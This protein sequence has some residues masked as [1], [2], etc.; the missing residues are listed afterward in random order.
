MSHRK[1]ETSPSSCE[2]STSN[3]PLEAERLGSQQGIPGSLSSGPGKKLSRTAVYAR[4]STELQRETSI[5]DQVD[6]CKRA[7]V[8]LG[9][10]VEDLRVFKDEAI[11]GKKSATAKRAGYQDLLRAIKG[12]ELDV[13]VCDQQCRLARSANEALAFFDEL[14][15]YKVR[16]VTADGFDSNNMTAELLFGIKSVFNAFYVDETR[17]RVQRSMAG[18]FERGVMVTAVPYGYS[19]DRSQDGVT[20]WVINEKQAEVMREVYTRR[21]QGM[22]LTQIAAVL[23]ANGVPTPQPERGIDGADK[24]WRHSGLWPMIRNTIYF[25]LYTVRLTTGKDAPGTVTRLIPEL[26]IVSHEDWLQAQTKESSRKAGN[27][28]GRVFG[29]VKHVFT[30]LL[31]CG[32]CGTRLSVHRLVNSTA[33]SLNCVQCENATRV[34]VCHRPVW[35][36][37][38]KGVRY[39]LQTLLNRMMQGD[40]LKQFH[41]KLRERL[42]GGRGA[43]L[44]EAKAQLDK[45]QRV[46]ARLIQMLDN[47][48]MSDE[49]LSRK[50]QSSCEQCLL[51]QR[52]V[53]DL[54][55]AVKQTDID[56]IHA[57][58]AVNVEGVID[59]FLTPQAEA[60]K[61]NAIL[62]S[63]FSQITLLY[64]PDRY[65]AIFEVHVVP[66]AVVAT[67]TGTPVLVNDHQVLHLCLITSGSRYPSWTLHD[68]T[69]DELADVLE[70]T[71]QAKSGD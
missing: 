49:D 37:S 24:Y 1:T 10:S 51:L 26:A 70:L 5:D 16:L 15:A 20:K 71:G 6:A 69:P 47:L 42:A 22:S 3:L 45:A 55:V 23:N 66:G 30:G 61:A 35:H 44:L 2:R 8:R 29:G 32:T 25:G 40:V 7:L 18:N 36:L 59:Q 43:E 58:L 60:H 53:A 52:R 56:A 48:S 54:E 34:G 68:L 62:K 12:G 13:I 67:A 9:H 57:Q 21:C 28:V 50:Y 64:K 41:D 63:V 11:S 27:G 4:Y 39:M 46:K 14:K 65:T 17:H 19:I 33:G 31:E 38:V